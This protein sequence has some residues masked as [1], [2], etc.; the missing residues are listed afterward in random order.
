MT[1]VLKLGGRK[2]TGSTVCKIF[3]EENVLWSLYQLSLVVRITCTNI[4]FHF[5][6]GVFYDLPSFATK[7]TGINE[8]ATNDGSHCTILASIHSSISEL[9]TISM[10]GNEFWSCC[11]Y[12]VSII[13]FEFSGDMN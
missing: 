10:N 4:N 5:K 11:F 7:I 9:V 13:S 6:T 1:G 3:S 12:T 8:V 2:N